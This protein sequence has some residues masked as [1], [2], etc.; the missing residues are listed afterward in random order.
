M[1]EQNHTVTATITDGSSTPQEGILVTFT[2]ISGPNQNDSDTDTTDATG[3]ATFTYTGDG[4]PGTDT[5][6]A[7]YENEA[8]QEICSQ[9]VTK[10]WNPPTTVT[11]VLEPEYELNLV[12]EPHTLIATVT[13]GSGLVTFTAISGPN[14]GILG[15]ANT[16]GTGKATLIYDISGEVG[17]DHI[18]ACIGTGESQVCSNVVQKEWTEEI[19]TLS[20]MRAQNDLNT[21]HTVTA[22]VTN[23]KGTPIANITV[24]FNV[25]AG[26]NAGD[27][28][29]DI[30][31]ANGQAT[32]TYTGDGGVG[33][34]YI[35]ACFTNAAG[36]Q[37]CTDYGETFDNDAVKEWGDACPAIKPNPATLPNAV[38]N[39]FYSQTITGFGGAEPY[40]FAVTALPDGLSLDPNTGVLSGTPTVSGA[41][42][43]TIT[44]TD[45][46]NCPGTRF[47]EFKV[48]PGINLSP[49]TQ[50][51][52]SGI[53]GVP[54]SQTISAGGGTGPYVYNLTGTLPP[55]LQW[56]HGSIEI[57][58]TPTA[59]GSW[60]FTVAVQDQGGLQC[61][62]SRDY[63]IRI[64]GEAPI[65]T[66]SEWGV[67]VML[68][69]LGGIGY[70]ALRRRGLPTAS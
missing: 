58:G 35:R 10:T 64:N 67:I 66:L 51:L 33:T 56:G 20:P 48:C 18:Q 36:D 38:I 70:A 7:C 60:T 46:D 16:D 37:V 26:P 30:T 19:L 69:L 23:L 1:V 2:V 14:Q 65:P 55:G 50:N 47:Y 63:T 22:T 25:K 4:G 24:N 52:P 68:L 8:G 34:D 21:Q 6:Q 42:S 62:T 12:G 49:S 43:F 32:F 41:F 39:V 54:Y 44:V 15:T 61:S 59:A 31:D 28:G 13:N 27:S 5:I 40:T 29:S 53:I 11:I 3:Q 45:I 57:W 9:A 17:I